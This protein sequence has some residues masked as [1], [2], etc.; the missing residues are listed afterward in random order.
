MFFFWLNLLCRL[1]TSIVL[2]PAPNSTA[3]VLWTSVYRDF[4]PSA[5]PLLSALM[6]LMRFLSI[7]AIRR[8]CVADSKTAFWSFKSVTERL[9]FG[10]S[11]S[12]SCCPKILGRKNWFSVIDLETFFADTT[13]I[14]FISLSL[15]RA[16]Y[17][18]A[19]V[20]F[21]TGLS[22]PS[23][24]W[25]LLFFDLEDLLLTDAFL[26]LGWTFC[27]PHDT[28]DRSRLLLVLWH[29]CLSTNCSVFCVCF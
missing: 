29:A 16:S 4:L 26:F 22:P 24:G 21:W 25:K 5:T 6:L 11:L 15:N 27:I 20:C 17:L 2:P 3:A 10:S 9:C 14:I 18:K 28:F 19:F 1:G 12:E 7:V 13:L 8:L 23:E